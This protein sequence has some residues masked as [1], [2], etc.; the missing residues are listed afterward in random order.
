MANKVKKADHS[1]TPGSEEEVIDTKYVFRIKESAKG[2]KEK[3][4]QHPNGGKRIYILLRH[5]V[6]RP[7]SAPGVTEQ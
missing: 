2:P 3:K 1:E 4:K 7:G 6:Q 5:R